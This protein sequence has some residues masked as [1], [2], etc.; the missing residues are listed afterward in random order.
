MI[1]LLQP[2]HV[3]I[4]KRDEE[5]AFWATHSGAEVDLFWQESGKNWAVEVK[6]ADAPRKTR[7]MSIVLNDLELAHL[8]VVYP[9]D[10]AYPLG[11]RVS[12]MPIGAIKD[13]WQYAL[14]ASR[15]RQIWSRSKPA[16]QFELGFTIGAPKELTLGYVWLILRG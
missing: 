12:A 1:R 16:D 8:W 2:W 15:N 10:K 6:Y 3:S 5:L 4:G 7:S 14:C 11:P 13:R 9:G